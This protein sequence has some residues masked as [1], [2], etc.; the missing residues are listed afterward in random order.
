MNLY[1]STMAIWQFG[2]Y[3]H[4]L[5]TRQL[6]SLQP[7]ARTRVNGF[8]S[9][10]QTR[11]LAKAKAKKAVG[12]MVT[13][14]QTPDIS[15]LEQNMKKHE[16]HMSFKMSLSCQFCALWLEAVWRTRLRHATRP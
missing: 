3:L 4:V 6:E 5:R 16:K 9:A 11:A 13:W 10:Q 15:T 1:W 2:V 7:P 14:Q 12:M 8:H